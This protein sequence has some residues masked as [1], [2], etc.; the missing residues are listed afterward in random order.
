MKKLKLGVI[1]LSEGNGHPYSWSAIFNGYDPKYMK[2]CPWQ[3]IPEYLS[4]QDFPKDAI[5]DVQ[6][7]HIW[8]QD[9]NSS[10]HIAKASR[11]PC[12]VDNME[13]I[14]GQVDGVLLARDDPENHYTMAKP[15][16]NVG[17][18]IFVDKP[19][20]TN[21]EE[22]ERIFALEQYKGQLFTCSS[23]RYGKSFQLN[24][25]LKK[26]L[27]AI[28]IAD[29]TIPKSWAKYSVHII[30]PMLNMLSIDNDALLNVT[31]TGAGEINIVTARWASGLCAVFKVLGSTKCSLSIRLFGSKAHQEFIFKDTYHAF[32][33]SLEMFI[34][35][36]REK[37]RIIPKAETLAV[38][39]IIEKGFLHP[40]MKEEVL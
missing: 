11:I 30:E 21:V 8:T 22:A 38:I 29:A 34:R 2:D 7:T 27:G 17:L 10:E 16:I 26:Q 9:R 23:L 37:R 28:Q 14:I 13:D 6:V 39:N 40:I 19:L 36:I 1:G 5:P 20:A 33:T 25:E 12:I 18:P 24:D 32:K 3:V 15:F 31:N 35:S 4:K